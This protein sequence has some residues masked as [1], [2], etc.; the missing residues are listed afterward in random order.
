RDR[1]AQLDVA[2]RPPP[3][4]LLGRDVVALGVP[5][6]PEVGRILREVYERQLDGAVTTPEQAREEARRLVQR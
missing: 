4:L 6:G 1:V 3:P 5:A 2:R